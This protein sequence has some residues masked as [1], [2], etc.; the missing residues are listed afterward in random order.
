MDTQLPQ[1]RKVKPEQLIKLFQ[2]KQIPLGTEE[3]EALLDLLYTLAMIF[4]Q[5]NPEAE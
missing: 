4:C 5:Q 1:H 3:A 2:S